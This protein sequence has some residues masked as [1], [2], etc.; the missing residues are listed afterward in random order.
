VITSLN[1]I[2]G[3]ETSFCYGLAD[4][5]YWSTSGQLLYFRTNPTI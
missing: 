1:F 3:V 5:H 4:K 2:F